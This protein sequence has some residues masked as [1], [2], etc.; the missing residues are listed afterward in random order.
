MV[1]MVDIYYKAGGTKEGN[2]LAKDL[3]DQCEEE[4]NFFTMLS[5]KVKASDDYSDEAGRLAQGMKMVAHYAETFGQKDLADGFNKRLKALNL[6]DDALLP[7][8]MQQPQPQQPM[9]QQQL[10]SLIKAMNIDT[11]DPKKRANR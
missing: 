9:N 7:E 1:Y 5:S 4:Y 10:E 6:S 11:S 3:F 8:D 2:Q